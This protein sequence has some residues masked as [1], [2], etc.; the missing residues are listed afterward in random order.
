MKASLL[1]L[2][3]S[4]PVCVLASEE[5]SLPHIW[6][7][8]N[9]LG[10]G[11]RFAESWPFDLSF[12]SIKPNG[13]GLLLRYAGGAVSFKINDVQE[14]QNNLPINTSYDPTI[15]YTFDFYSVKLAFPFSQ[16]ATHNSMR[17]FALGY[18]Y[19][20][21]TAIL[22]MKYADPIYGAVQA[23]QKRNLHLHSVELIYDGSMFVM[24]GWVS[25]SLNLTFGFVLNNYKMPFVD[26]IKGID[27]LTNYVPGL[28]FGKR[29]YIS[30]SVGIG[31]SL[32]KPVN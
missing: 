5:D 32:F 23:I 16:N 27:N 8:L 17:I 25:M 30:P 18:G 22:D 11:L 26:K 19:S 3:L 4:L 31:I 20:N 15:K 28:G 10:I 14:F 24:N 2:W 7:R 21:A 6:H 29:V 1:F 12:K 9:I 13:P